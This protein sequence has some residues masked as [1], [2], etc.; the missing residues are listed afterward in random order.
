MRRLLLLD[1]DGTVIN[2][3]E[4]VRRSYESVGV[5]LPEG[6]WG[7]RWQDWLIDACDGDRERAE[8]LHKQKIDAYSDLLLRTD[9][10]QF[11]LPGAPLARNWRMWYGR[12]YLGYLTAGAAE[13]ACTIAARL[14]GEATVH[15]EL[16][17]PE[18]LKH[19]LAAPHGTIYLDDNLDTIAQLTV[20]APHLSL[21]AI[22][23]Q[24]YAAV[25]H[26]VRRLT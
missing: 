18:R 19:L 15:G 1:V 11:E 7:R 12:P 24:P 8:L 9:L 22:T 16:T 26:E 23:G 17:Y 6:A 2:S 13:T 4:L 10:K 20:D 5:E 25:L 14:H 21:I 3:H